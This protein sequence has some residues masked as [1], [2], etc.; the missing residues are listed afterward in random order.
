M[1][2]LLDT[3]MASYAVDQQ[4]PYHHAVIGRL[5]QLAVDDTAYLSVLTLYEIEYGVVLAPADKRDKVIAAHDLL[6]SLFPILPITVQGSTV[7]GQLK[8]NYRNKTGIHDKA[9]ERH[10]I[11]FVIASGALVED[12]CRVPQSIPSVC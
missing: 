2:Y 7:F 9:L 8:A 11:D 3:N 5:S 12:G 10:N 4:S 6:K 1:K